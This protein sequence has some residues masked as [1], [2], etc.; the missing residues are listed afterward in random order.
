MFDRAQLEVLFLLIK[1]RLERPEGPRVDPPPVAV[2]AAIA[3]A[4][5]RLT[6]RQRQC[7]NLASATEG[8]S[9]EAIADRMGIA[10][11]TV[12]RYLRDLYAAL[13]VRTR[14]AMVRRAV[15]YGVVGVW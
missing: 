12:D 7:C 6:A 5:A 11:H 3:E 2:D 10:T 14:S 1:E 9:K 13:R 8:F 4:V 15:Q